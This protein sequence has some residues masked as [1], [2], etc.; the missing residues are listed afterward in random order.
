[1][2]LAGRLGVLPH[3]RF[4][5][6]VPKPEFESQ[7]ECCDVIVNLR[8]PLTKHMSATLVRGLAA[9]R[10]LVVTE[11]PDWEFLP[12]DACIPVPAG[13][14]E[15]EILTSQLAALAADPEMRARRAAAAL[16]WYRREGTIERMAAGYREVIADVSAGTAP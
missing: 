14:D 1:V 8:A 6:Y 2:A 16:E 11:L 13:D 4:A 9:G 7:L 12:A 10:P 5:G 15:V 3:V